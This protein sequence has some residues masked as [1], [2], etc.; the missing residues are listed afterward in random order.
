ML[1]RAGL[2]PLETAGQVFDPHFHQA[3]ETLEIPGARDQEIVEELQRGYKLKHQ[4]LRP[5]HVRV[6]AGTRSEKPGTRSGQAGS[7]GA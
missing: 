3:V 2:V 4:L 7:D 1:G 6:A 5:A